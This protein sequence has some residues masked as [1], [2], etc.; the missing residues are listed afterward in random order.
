MDS[1]SI[2]SYSAQLRIFSGSAGP[3]KPPPIND[4]DGQNIQNAQ[5]IQNVPMVQ[6]DPPGL[7]SK[8]GD[9][10]SMSL[11]ARI[12]QISMTRSDDGVSDLDTKAMNKLKAANLS[13]NAANNANADDF[14]GKLA[15]MGSLK[16]GDVSANSAATGSG[17]NLIKS[18]M[19]AL[20]GFLGNDGGVA[21]DQKVESAPDQI[22]GNNKG[23]HHSH[24]HPMGNPEDV[25]SK[26]LQHLQ[27]EQ[28]DSGEP[29]QVFVDKVHQ[30]MENRR[31]ALKN[32]DL[33]KKDPGQF[34][35]Y[36]SQVDT[37]ITSGL[38]A[39]AHSGGQSINLQA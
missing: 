4:K 8:D 3:P 15:S 34:N 5:N 37:L 30:K 28:A 1:F 9:S 26:V 36:R 20:S 38:T 12:V 6:D 33:S 2:Q 39:W 10:F 29:L 23:H 32:Q 14:L 11:E 16:A 17:T 7:T 22:R 35:E 18:M 27:Q 31:D 19:Q 25:A 21:T 13:A 24:H